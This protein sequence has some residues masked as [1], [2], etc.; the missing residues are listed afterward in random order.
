MQI[1]I[2]RARGAR[3][4]TLACRAPVR[5]ASSASSSDRRGLS[6][7]SPIAA[8]F[9]KCR[10]R[11]AD[12]DRIGFVCVDETRKLSRKRGEPI[13]GKREMRGAD[14]R[15][16]D[17]QRRSA[18]SDSLFNPASRQDFADPH[19]RRRRSRRPSRSCPAGERL[20]EEPLLL[21]RLAE[22]HAQHAAMPGVGHRLDARPPA[23]DKGLCARAH[24]RSK[25]VR[26]AVGLVAARRAAVRCRRPAPSPPSSA[27]ACATHDSCVSS[28]LMMY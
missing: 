5:C 3:Q 20:L 15:G 16:C 26:C 2:Q 27:I 6:V 7:V 11:I 21:E 8:A 28:R 10:L 19:D 22:N 18:T 1:E 14:R 23:V 4:G 12:A 17:P 9:K 25:M 24:P 13:A